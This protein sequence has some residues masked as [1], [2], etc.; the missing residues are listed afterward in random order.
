MFP[1]DST[2]LRRV[3]AA[4]QICAQAVILVACLILIGASLFAAPGWTSWPEIALSLGGMPVANAGMWLQI[5]LT[6]L[7]AML[8]FWLPAN[9][10]MARLETG[11]RSVA[12]GVTDVAR[13]CRMSHETARAGLF[14]LS[15]DFD[16]SRERMEQLRRHP[17]FAGLEPELL[18]LAAQMNHETRALAQSYSNAKVARAK[19]VLQQHQEEIDALSE[20]LRL[21]RGTCNEMRRWRAAIEAAESPGA[22]SAQTS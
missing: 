11:H 10:R 3:F 4:G 22:D 17:D 8:V 19:G 7:M 21:A 9:A 14:G 13:A 1:E 5:G 15:P 6:V 16:S 18:Q 2:L 12:M 20:R